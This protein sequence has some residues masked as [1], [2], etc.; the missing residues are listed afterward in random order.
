MPVQ[1]RKEARHNPLSE[2]RCQ[3][4]LGYVIENHPTQGSTMNCILRKIWSEVSGWPMLTSEWAAS[5]STGTAAEDGCVS[6]TSQVRVSSLVFGLGLLLSIPM[7]AHAQSLAMGGITQCLNSFLPGA[8]R[9][10]CVETGNASASGSN[11]VAIGAFSVASAAN[12]VALGDNSVANRVNTVSVGRLGGERQITNVAAGVEASD[13][14]NKAQLDVAARYFKANGADDGSDAAQADGVGASAAGV[15]SQASGA[16]STALGTYNAAIGDHASAVGYMNTAGGVNSSAMG[17]W[18]QVDGENSSAFGFSNSVEGSNALA[19]GSNSRASGNASLV[20]GDSAHATADNAIA[21]GT[22]AMASA[23]NAVA[24]GAGSV[25]DRASA[26]SV[27]AVNAERQII[28]VAAGT[29]ATDAVNRAQLDVVSETTAANKL[30]LE[31]VSEAAAVNKAQ[32]EA[33]SE[34]ADAAGRYFQGEGL[35]D[36]SDDAMV[37]GAGAVAIGRSAVAS[38]INAV[39]LGAGSLADRDNALSVGAVNAER[40]IINVASGTQATDAVNKAQLDV[41]SETADAA[42]RYFQGEGVADGSDDAIASGAGAVAI[43]RSAVASAINAVALGAGSVAD[44]DNAISVGAVNAERQIINVAS[45]TQATDAVNKAQLD[46]VSGVAGGTGRYFKSNGAADG[47]DDA[48]ASGFGASA[49]GVGSLASGVESTALG[50]YNVAA[51]DYAIAVGYV[52]TANGVNSSA[53]GNFNQVDGENSSAFGFANV[54]SGN[55]AL[56]V[57]S[58]SIASGNGSLAAGNSAVASGSNAV[59]LGSGSQALEDNVISVGGGDG[60]NG[61]MTRRIVNVGEGRLADDSTD[62]INGSQLNATNRRVATVE[63][64][65]DDFDARIESVEG[66]AINAV[67]YDGADRTALTLSGTQGTTLNNVAAGDIAAGSMQATNGGQLYD[68]LGAMVSA[69]GSGAVLGMQGVIVAPTYVIQSASYNTVGDALKALDG[70]VSALNKRVADGGTG[71][72]NGGGVVLGDR[73]IAP[74]AAGIGIGDDAHVAGNSGIAL[75]SNA[76]VLGEGGTAV[77]TN[78][79]ISA[80]ADAAV[81]LGDGAAVSASGGIA[82]GSGAHVTASGSVALGQG[83]VADRVNTLSVGSTGHERQI[84]HVAAGTQDTDAVNKSQLDNGITSANAYTDSQLSG[85]NDRFDVLR[86][87]MG[88]RLRH[89]DRRIDRQGAMNAAMLNMS[90]SMAGVRTENRVGVGVGFQ[91]GESSLSIGYQRAFS[92]RA[93]LTVGGAFSSDDSSVGVG[94]G[95]GW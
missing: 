37:S 42:G 32:L 1:Q 43:G 82:I 38:A 22:A 26:V 8:A 79:R 68:S 19:I 11:A 41:V 95:F 51:G 89:V 93:T 31:V 86:N 10:N 17:N 30:Q 59:A 44:R 6:S 24:L 4:A 5:P 34:T 33:V 58:N 23:V 84:A 54:A 81:A 70:E 61:P 50:N 3:V 18:N 45:G 62:A 7:P 13:A 29:Q 67:S 75:G 87:D 46:A 21:L 65:V 63:T 66:V 76:H 60:S 36:G 57:G 94:A 64:R 92:D 16:E 40:Q 25:A 88:E 39:A 47:S 78:T 12:S 90:T 28:N 73:V 15:G 9:V 14:V 74:G 53:V 77:G 20:A 2:V 35:A 69:L 85:M 83:S 27:G 52:N 48:I 56:V 91:S 49:A 55:N 72:N 71:G 80:G